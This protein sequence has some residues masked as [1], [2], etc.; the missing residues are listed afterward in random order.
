MIYFG[1]FWIFTASQAWD[2]KR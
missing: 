1:I 2:A